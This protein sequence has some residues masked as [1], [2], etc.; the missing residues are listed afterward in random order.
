M[1]IGRC[2]TSRDRPRSL[3][4]RSVTAD[5]ETLVVDEEA[6]G[7]PMV[8]DTSSERRDPLGPGALRSASEEGRSN[9]QRNRVAIP[10]L[11]IGIGIVWAVNSL[12]I[13][14]PANQFFASFGSTAGSFAGSTLGGPGISNFV[15]SNA[16]AFSILLAGVTLYLAIAL[17]LGLTTRIACVVGAVFS[18]FLVLTQFGV[19]FFF[20]GG[21][22]VGPHPIYILVYVALLIGQAGRTFSLDGWLSARWVTG[23]L[24]R[25][26]RVPAKKPSISA[27]PSGSR[28]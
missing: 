4:S 16:G 19:T 24:S 8:H 3:L 25:A 26:Q 17:V 28:D 1:C 9:A 22:D 14:L 18:L 2:G 11:R 12:F 7:I 6:Q 21:T 23:R 13:L 27:G 10:A 15:A 5:I 20:P